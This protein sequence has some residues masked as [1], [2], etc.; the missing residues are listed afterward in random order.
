LL[1][2]VYVIDSF[3]QDLKI[4]NG[5]AMYSNTLF[6]ELVKLIDRSEF[7]KMVNGHASDKYSKGF[8]S[9]QHVM[10]MLLCQFSGVS[11]LREAEIV[12]GNHSSFHYHLNLPA[13]KR[14]TLSKSNNT[15]TPG[16]F[17]DLAMQ[18]MGRCRALNSE[19]GSVLRLIDSS[20]II[21]KGRNNQW[22]KETS[23]HRIEGLKLHLSIEPDG[24]A[25]D[26]LNITDSRVNDIS[27]AVGMPLEAGKIYVFDKGYCDYN[28]WRNI[29]AAGSIFV[30]RLKYNAAYKMVKQHAIS[31]E[32]TGFILSDQT[33]ELTNKS[34]RGGK[35]NTLAGIALRLIEV[36]RP[37]GKKPLMI[38]C[39][40]LEQAAEIIAGY[41]KTRW[42]IEL[43]FKWIKRYL[44][45]KTF[46]GESKNSIKI[47]LYCAII[48]YLLMWM[49]HKLSDCAL[50]AG[51]Q[52]RVFIQTKLFD[53]IGSEDYSRKRRLN[54]TTTATQLA[55]EL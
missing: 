12:H 22:T 46:L 3:L 38:V 32:N 9:W 10:A 5:A 47:Q 27:D 34:P 15:R 31:T 52:S 6:S 30:T 45:V 55:L 16:L 19:L 36:A 48:A 33:I 21:Y 39:N 35:K 23:C 24:N 11:S 43:F 4:T 1:P 18:L 26:Y 49:W 13:L 17:R 2:V 7:S 20:P 54:N 53:R 42:Q 37:D 14:S 41:Y 40:D 8:G 25:L 51:T 44:K 50:R 29:A 28:W